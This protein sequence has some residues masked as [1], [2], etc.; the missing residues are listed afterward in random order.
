MPEVPA[1]YPW[2]DPRTQPRSS[3]PARAHA[4]TRLLSNAP[5]RI[6]VGAAGAHTVDFG[7]HFPP[8]YMR[9]IYGD[10]RCWLER[11]SIPPLSEEKMKT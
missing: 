7:D 8:L 2:F 10:K 11:R 6:N 4:P 9:K 1:S 3:S 5:N